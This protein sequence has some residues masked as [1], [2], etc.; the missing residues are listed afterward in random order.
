MTEVYSR[1]PCQC[2]RS[3]IRCKGFSV[4]ATSAYKTSTWWQEVFN[5]D[6]DPCPSSVAECLNPAFI[7]C[8]ALLSFSQLLHRHLSPQVLP[9]DRQLMTPLSGEVSK[10]KVGQIP[11]QAGCPSFPAGPMCCCSSSLS[12]SFPTCL[13]LPTPD[14]TAPRLTRTYL[15]V[16]RCQCCSCG[17]KLFN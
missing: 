5:G 4:P 12:R 1:R 3:W 11:E 15:W 7:P 9:P 14:K 13:Q 6:V 2:V 17:I 16:R 8:L 10:S